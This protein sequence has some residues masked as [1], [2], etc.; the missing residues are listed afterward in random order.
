MVGKSFIM[1]YEVILAPNPKHMREI[2][3]THLTATANLGP[4]QKVTNDF[5]KQ[6]RNRLIHGKIIPG[7]RLLRECRIARDNVILPGY[8]LPS[9][10]KGPLSLA[11]AC[12]HS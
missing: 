7:V 11:K 10:K 1:S 6:N 8:V 2:M 5:E 4:A 12:V 3:I 9:Q